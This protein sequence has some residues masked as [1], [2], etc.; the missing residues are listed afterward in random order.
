MKDETRKEEKKWECEEAGREEKGGGAKGKI[1]PCNDHGAE[2]QKPQSFAK[3]KVNIA[4]QKKN[5]RK[6]KKTFTPKHKKH[7]MLL[8]SQCIQA[9]KPPWQLYINLLEMA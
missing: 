6:Q 5:K 3:E 8:S 2:P 9:F 7:K 1:S 4:K